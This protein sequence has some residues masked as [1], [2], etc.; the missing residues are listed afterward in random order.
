MSTPSPSFA[1]HRVFAKSISLEMPGGAN[2]FRAQANPDTDIAVQVMSSELS[3]GVYEVALRATV[4]GKLEGKPIY[5]LEVEQAGVFEVKDAAPA[6]LADILDIAIPGILGPYLRALLAD[7]LTR[8]T[9]PVLFLPDINWT[10]M[11]ADA[12]AKAAGAAADAEFS[13][14]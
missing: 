3:N 8:A 1:V 12:R 10:A 2:I 14:A 11:A 6:Q 13:P 7:V 4:T 9:L 5:L